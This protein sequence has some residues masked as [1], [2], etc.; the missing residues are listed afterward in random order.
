MAIPVYLALSAAEF[1]TCASLPPKPAWMACHFSSDGTGLSNIPD[2]LPPGS[3]LI[4]D[5]STPWQGH[6]SDLIL[7]Q[8]K[9]AV[10]ML[11]PDAL[12]LD[13]QRPGVDAVQ[14]LAKVIAEQLP[15]PVAVSSCY[16]ENLTCPIFLP[17]GPLYKPLSDYLKPY[18]N[19]E[20]WLDAAPTCG[21]MIVTPAGANYI[22]EI[23]TFLPK[24]SHFDKSLHCHYRTKIEEDQIIFTFSRSCDDLVGWLGEAESLGV[25]CAIGLHQELR[26]IL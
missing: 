18:Q 22:P 1:L 26:S 20:V 19:R 7:T 9:N 15:C 6:D 21:Q 14:S 3:L 10:S 5:D 4:V 2:T 25:S 13:F 23:N 24:S 8:I 17:P 11:R 16:A 12:L